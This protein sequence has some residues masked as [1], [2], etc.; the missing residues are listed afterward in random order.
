MH[1]MSAAYQRQLLASSS[2]VQLHNK[3]LADLC[4]L[5]F[6]APSRIHPPPISPALT[7]AVPLTWE[8][9]AVWVIP[10]SPAL[11]ATPPCAGRLGPVMLVPP[12]VCP[13]IPQTPCARVVLRQPLTLPP[14]PS[15]QRTRL[16]ASQQS[17]YFGGGCGGWRVLLFVYAAGNSVD[18]L[19]VL[20]HVQPDGLSAT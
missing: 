9:P 8:T 2:A 5:P 13:V 18:V 20:F 6:C 12:S 10:S 7:A 4:L 14:E 19:Q 15:C 16:Q 1:A 3:H 17:G 11:D